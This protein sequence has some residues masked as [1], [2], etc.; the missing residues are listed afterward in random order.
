V[1]DAAID[2]MRPSLV[3]IRV[4]FTEYREGREMKAQAVGSGAIITREGHIVTNHHVAG[5]AVRMICT[6][7]NREEIEAELVGTDPLTDISI[8]KLKPDQ[9]R[10]FV[11]AAFGDS[12]RV[13]VGDTVLAMGSPMALSQSVTLGII[14]NSEMMM[15]RMFGS[16]GRF[17]LD[18]EDVGSLV[19]WIGHDAAIYGGNSGGPLV[20]LQGEI[21]GINEIRFGLSGAIPGSLAHH[22]AD[23]LI[24]HGKVRRSWLGIDVQ[25]LFKHG[26]D[27]H[28]VLVSGVVSN[29][30]AS[31][32]GLQAGD[33]LMRIGDTSTNV[34]YDEE[35]PDF[36]RLV[37]SLPIGKPVSAVV[38]RAGKEMKFE[39][40]P[41]ERGEL[42]LK[43]QELKQWGLTVRDLS[44]LTSREMKRTNQLGVLVSSVRPGGPSGEAKP[45]LEPKDVLI[46]VNGK[47]ISNVQD[48]LVITRQLTE[49]KSDP[50]PAVASFERDSQRYLTVVK[51][52]I[53][54][55]RDP[56]LEVAKAWLPVETHVISRDIARE[57]QQP[58]LK[59]FYITEVYPNT[60]AEKAG[61]KA[62]D[63]ITAVDDQ[64]LTASGPELEE[65]LTTLIHQYDIGAKV[66]LT[67]VR[68][69]EKLKIPIQL[70]RSPKLKR[71][72]RKYRNEDFEFTARDLSFFDR[73]EE[74][75]PPSQRGALVEDVK[76]GSWA[77]LGSLSVDDLIVEVDG[78]PVNNVDA[79]KKVLSEIAQNRKSFVVMKVLRGIHTAYLELEPSWK[80]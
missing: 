8:I 35:M 26:T 43:E 70:E 19:R 45:P 33:L 20:N 38:L 3:R 4:V 72:M 57:L 28:G 49:G 53:Q 66:E 32:V 2:R 69:K 68:D 54:E 30:P 6:L 76:P 10:E 42:N 62:G 37:T 23:E 48:L 47:A 11:P 36:M 31:R 22:I 40:E 7:W 58:D 16:M 39:L 65:E 34:R 5:H 80:K 44:F 18:G 13:R 55:L 24:A 56:G 46:E 12:T 61:L 77:E 64:K 60:A 75:W 50:V 71:E 9:P 63:F 15:P 25:P 14:S 21:I 51:V 29:S 17:R 74:Q 67:V 78:Q 59:G 73:A 1:V 79:L 27:E 52:G 41:V